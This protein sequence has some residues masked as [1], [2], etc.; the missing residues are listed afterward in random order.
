MIPIPDA[1]EVVDQDRETCSLVIG[2]IYQVAHNADTGDIWVP[3]WWA[4]SEYSSL[5]G[6]RYDWMPDPRPYDRP[7]EERNWVPRWQKGYNI[8]THDADCDMSFRYINT[9]PADGFYAF[10]CSTHRQWAYRR[11]SKVVSHYDYPEGR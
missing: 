3:F 5:T 9:N 11:P 7:W 10:W 1:I 2:N 6:V 4:G 8:D